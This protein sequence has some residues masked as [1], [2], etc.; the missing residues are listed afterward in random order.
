MPQSFIAGLAFACMLFAV[1]A[2]P[3]SLLDDR[4]AQSSKPATPA[5]PAKG[6]V[7]V[8][9]A[10]RGIGLELARQCVQLGYTVVG[11]ARDVGE[12]KEL[13][14]TGAEILQLDVSDAASTAAFAKALEGRPV[15]ILFNNAGVTG[16]GSS[17]AELDLDAAARAIAVN[18]LGPMRV[19]KALLPNLK[20]GSRKTVVTI[21]SALA[22]IGNNERG[23]YLGYRESKAA[24]NM[25]MR[26]LA[27]EFR[28]DGFI[29]VAMS[30]GWVRTDMGGSSAP[31]SPEESVRGILS[32]VRSLE[33]KD[34]GSFIS[35]DGSR[36]PW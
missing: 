13:K 26:S 1:F 35:H 6:L 27:A 36:L 29:A 11:T 8:T 22:S 32:V 5:P 19:T 18:T 20:A 12:A 24:V 34:S 2:A 25:F 10:N 30:P 17:L 15:E 31:L 3:M 21:S 14:A 33:Q 23:G 16:G 7:V 9:G 4:P 28:G